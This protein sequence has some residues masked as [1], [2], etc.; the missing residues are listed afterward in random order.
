MGKVYDILRSFSADG[1]KIVPFDEV[2]STNNIAKQLARQ[3]V[4]DSTV[5][6]AARQ[7]GGRGRKGRSFYSPEG[8]GIYMSVI[9]RGREIV[10]PAEYTATAAVAVARTADA[11]TGRR[12]GIK[13]VNDI[14]LDGRKVCGIL[15]ES[16]FSE[17][18]DSADFVVIGIGINLFEPQGGFPPEIADRAGA[19]FDCSY[20][21]DGVLEQVVV[22]VL[23]ELKALLGGDFVSTVM[24]EYRSRSVLTNA[25][26][27]VINVNGVF[28]ARVIGITDRAELV[29]EDKNNFRFTL[30][31][32][33]VSVKPK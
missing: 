24:P 29:V 26:V 6:I 31:S 14:Y 10:D 12:A 21:K 32:G 18:D 19:F 3:G 27:D 16:A 30:S 9:L 22:G 23:K 4:D 5:V 25:N 33:E 2:D 20:P 15:A 1:Y 13:W 28:E 8:D 17:P 7:T 11:V